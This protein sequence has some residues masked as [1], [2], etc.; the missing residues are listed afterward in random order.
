MKKILSLI[1][2]ASMGATAIAQTVELSALGSYKSTWLFNKNI[3]DLGT[4]EDYA[5][6]WG[7]NFGLGATFYFND[8]IGLEVNALSSQHTGAYTG[9]LGASQFN[10]NS[11]ITLKQLDFP[12]MFVLSNRSAY[13][14]VGGQYSSI[15][16][17]T[18]TY[19]PESG[20]T[21]TSDVFSHYNHTNISGILGFGANIAINDHWFI[22][23]GLRIEYGLTDL[24]GVDAQ[25]VLLSD[26]FFYPKYEKTNSA[27]GGLMIGIAYNF[28]G[29]KE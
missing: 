26:P 21:Y 6:G 5:A 24:K 12:L 13:L 22:K 29:K 11:N 1:L 4:T 8:M 19:K 9:S 25:G 20:N 14:E 16:S 17:A 15:S 3:S 23:A 27:A 2:F 10:Y 18:Y 28:K 7:Y